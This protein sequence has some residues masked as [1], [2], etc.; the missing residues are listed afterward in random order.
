MATLDGLLNKQKGQALG[1]RAAETTWS[2][3]D[4][5]EKPSHHT[6]NFF[7]QGKMITASALIAAEG[8]QD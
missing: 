4:C 2:R 8:N 7:P 3:P 1:K 5:S 6:C